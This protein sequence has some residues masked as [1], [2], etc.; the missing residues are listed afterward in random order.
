MRGFGNSCKTVVGITLALHGNEIAPLDALDKLA[1]LELGNYLFKIIIVNE[2]A[3]EV[4]KRYLNKDLNRIFPGKEDGNYEEKLAYQVLNELKDCEFVLDFH[5]SEGETPPFIITTKKDEAHLNLATKLGL[6]NVVFMKE[7]VSGGKSLIDHCDLAVSIELG[8]HSSLLCGEVFLNVIKSLVNET[9]N[10]PQLFEAIEVLKKPSSAFESS[11]HNF[12]Q[13]IEGD[14]IAL[15]GLCKLVA[16]GEAYPILA[17]EPD[18]TDIL[19][20]LCRKC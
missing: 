4:N 5:T 12:K 7:N 2:K 3:I 6:Q 11:I 8:K 13:I 1:K 20:I 19:C 10:E 18:Y 15:N 17:G 16:T 9:R 14:T